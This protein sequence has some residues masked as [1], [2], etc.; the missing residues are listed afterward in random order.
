MHLAVTPRL[1]AATVGASVAAGFL[2]APS[3]DAIEPTAAGASQEAA[4]TP[5]TERLLEPTPGAAGIGDRYWPLDG[6]GGID[7]QHYDIV[8]SY[9]FADGHLSGTTT[10]TVRATQALSSFQ[11]DFLL[12]VSA[13]SVDGVDATYDRPHRHE[14]RIAPTTPLVRGERFE[15]VV[16]YAGRP[17]PIRYARERNWAADGDE[18]V[19]MNEP[20]MAPWW[21][22]SNDHPTDKARFDV[23]ITGPATHRTIS[24]GLLVDRVVAGDQATTH[25]RSSDPMVPYLAFFALGRYDVEHGVRNGLPWYV[26]V[27]REL[28]DPQRRRAMTSLERSPAVTAWLARR[29]GPYPFESTGGVAPSIDVGFALENQTR[30]TYSGS[31][32]THL[33]TIVHELAH[34][35]FGDSV[36]VRR[37]HDI[38][39]NEGFATF[40]EAAY[41]EKHGGRSAQQWLRAQYDS[42]RGEASF[43]RLDL[44]DPGRRHIFDE[45]VYLRGAMALQALRHRIGNRVFWATLQQWVAERQYGTGSVRAFRRHVEQVSGTDLDRFFRVWLTTP[46]APTVTRANGLR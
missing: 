8:N 24:N 38:W 40:M 37:W 22:P 1:L 10:L 26:A 43:W 14:L 6:N 19:T 12:P 20:H 27:S 25:W 28:P 45:P 30:P 18:V 46:R 29:L 23:T 7:V 17:G 15:V 9:D 44:A 4:A 11:L 31:A 33:P 2:A 42:R 35:W 5:D 21:F 41:A 34:Q 13:V 39:L 36:S 3:G 16:Q 32:A